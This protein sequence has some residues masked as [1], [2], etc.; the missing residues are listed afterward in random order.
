[1]QTSVASKILRVGHSPDPDDA[2]MFYALSKGAVSLPGYEIEHVIEDIQSLNRRAMRSELDVTAISAAVYP[3]VAE[4]YW[5]LA[6]GASVGRNYGPKVIANHKLSRQE[7]N[8]KRIAVPGLQ[9][10]AYLLLKIF[11]NDF[12]PVEMSFEKIISA[13][14]TSQ[15]DAGLIIHEGQLNYSNFGLKCCLD[16]GESWYDKYQ[17]PIPLGL[18][19]VR[20]DLGVATAKA[21]QKAIKES[22][23]FARG[24]ESQALDYA[25]QFGRGISKDTAKIFCGMYVNEDTEDLGAS[26]EQALLLL[27]QEG[28][29]LGLFQAPQ[30]LEIIR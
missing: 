24:K 18:D 20:K 7:L 10:T 19:I 5:I 6:S 2:F 22:I 23:V 16:L 8:G 27:F 26:G 12:T 28:A 1:M 30:K 21:V 4:N 29:A 9:T 13:V 17:L 14:Q 3:Q 11:L 25:L 15:V